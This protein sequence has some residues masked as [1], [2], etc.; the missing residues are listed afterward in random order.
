VDGD[1]A[2]NA[3]DRCP[4]T[5]VGAIADTN[6]CS[7]AQVD[8]DQDGFCDP[9]PPSSGPGPCTGVDNCPNVANQSQADTDGDGYGD[10]CD[11]CV[12]VAGHW[13]VPANDADCDGWPDAVE[14]YVGT[15]PGTMCAATPDPRD[16]TADVWPTDLNNDQLVNGQD[17][18]SFNRAFGHTTGQP[19]YQV[20]NDLNQDGLINGQDV[21]QFNPFFGKRCV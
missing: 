16:E 4:N 5:A 9:N 10:A 12:A 18:L 15:D 2:A 21:L 20:R 8:R 6:G 3:G 11:G 7:D 19:E 14:Q 17:I 13:T 1:G